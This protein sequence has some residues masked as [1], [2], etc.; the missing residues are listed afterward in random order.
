MKRYLLAAVGAALAFAA[1]VAFATT[2]EASHRS[3]RHHAAGDIAMI[4]VPARH[5]AAFRRAHVDRLIGPSGSWVGPN[6]DIYRPYH[7]WRGRL[8]ILPPYQRHGYANAAHR[9]FACRAT[10]HGKVCRERV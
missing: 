7:H 9:T 2:A 3:H 1:I 6:R 4:D 8:V 10:K 5:V